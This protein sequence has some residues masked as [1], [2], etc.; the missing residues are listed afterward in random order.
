MST[1]PLHHRISLSQLRLLVAL[2]E[3]G[4][5]QRAADAVHISQP[6]A[7]KALQQL[8]QGAGEMLVQRRGIGS[9]LTP[10]GE[11]LCRRARLVLAELQDAERELGLWHSGA[12]GHI[13]IGTL[14]VSTPHLVPIALSQ[15]LQVAPRITTTVLEG[16]SEAMFKDLKAGGIDLLVGRF[17]PG[18]D[19]ELSTEALYK[20]VFR[21]GVRTGHP[22]TSSPH[23]EWSDVLAY[24]WVLPPAG[25][26]TRPALDDMFRRALVSPPKTPVE[27]TSYLVM[28]SLMFNSNIVCPMPIE[29][30]QDD[31]KLGLTQ[32]LPFELDLTVPPISVVWLGKRDPSPAARAF[33][34]QLRLVSRGKGP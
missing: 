3:T 15:L 5:L 14:P 4:S 22:L 30:F 9:V 16:N 33:I 26:R 31:V 12:A 27:S 32:L 1:S 21:L 28:R 11:I 20:S 6:A 25:V 8:E 17:Y 7:T 13:T 29:V 2:A 10:Q 34:E 19:E 18:Q 24:P 23:L